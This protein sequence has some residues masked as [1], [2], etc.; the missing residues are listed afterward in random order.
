MGFGT[1]VLV[2]MKA[3]KAISIAQLAK[4]RFSWV[5]RLS[6]RLTQP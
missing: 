6:L 2:A 5:C 3:K 1:S 4:R